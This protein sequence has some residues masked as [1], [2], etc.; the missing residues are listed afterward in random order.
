MGAYGGP[1]ACNF[2]DADGDGAFNDEDNCILRANGPLIP[3]AG[4]NI[5]R[6]TDGDNYG[7]YCDPDFNGD[8]V[9]SAA[10]LAYMKINFFTDDPD[11]DLTGDGTVSAADLAILKTMFF[12]PPGPSGLVP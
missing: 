12:G 7:N 11:A 3:D 1:G 4:G 10:D 5:Q 9:V 6:D 2:T 8:G